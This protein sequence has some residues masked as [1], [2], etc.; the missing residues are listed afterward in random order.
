[1]PYK[2]KAELERKNW[3]TIPEAVVDICTADHC[4]PKAAREQLRK[5]LTDDGLWLLRWQ[6]EKGDRTPPWGESIPVAVPDDL[7]PRG[8]VWESAKIRWQTG[9]VRDDW[10]DYNKGKWRVL[11]IHRL[12]LAHHW[13]P[14]PTVDPTTLG[15]HASNVHSTQTDNIVSLSPHSGDDRPSSGWKT[16]RGKRPRIKNYLSKHFADRVPD[17]GV[18]PRNALKADIL[19]A[20]SSLEPLDEATLKSAIDEYNAEVDTRGAPNPN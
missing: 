20:D 17:P 1:M 6:L 8:E 5:A 12:A 3:K 10:G 11:L 15:S 16:K 9:R 18:C 19:K 4:D 2:T 13:Q 7:P 14:T